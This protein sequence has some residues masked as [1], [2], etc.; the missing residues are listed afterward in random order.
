VAH[1]LVA[2]RAAR[3]RIGRGRASAAGGFSFAY[4]LIA[5]LV[6]VAGTI[7]LLNRTS[8]SLLGMASQRQSLQAREAARIGMAYLIS[9]INRPRNRNLLAVSAAQLAA[10]PTVD[11]AIWSDVAD[12]QNKCFSTTTPPNAAALP[13]LGDLRLAGGDTSF[14]YIQPDGA[15]TGE[16]LNATLAFRVHRDNQ[17]NN[18][19]LARRS[20]LSLTDAGSTRGFFRLSVEGRVLAPGSERVIASTILQEDF[21]V[22]PK[23]CGMS[24][25]GSASTS[26]GHGSSDFWAFPISEPAGVARSLSNHLSQNGVELANPA[27]S[28]LGRIQENPATFVDLVMPELP[29]FPGS[30][31]AAPLRL[32]TP[33]PPVNC[34]SNPSGI[35]GSTELTQY[36]STATPPYTR[37]NADTV[38]SA[39]L[40]GNCVIRDDDLHCAITDLTLTSGQMVFVSG[41]GTRRIRLYFADGGSII[42][43]PGD[44]IH[45][46]PTNMPP[47]CLLNNVANITDLSIFG[48]SVSVNPACTSVGGT[49]FQTITAR[50]PQVGTGFF[51]Y[52][53]QASVSIQY[54]GIGGNDFRGVV[55]ARSIN[56]TAPSIVPPV[57]PS[58]VADAFRLVGLL[59]N[60]SNSFS[61]S[62]IVDGSGY[63]RR[64]NNT[65]L[66]RRA[67]ANSFE[68][69]ARSTNRFRFIGN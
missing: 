68:T 6:L 28:V 63:G 51:V 53:P 29:R 58:G 9:Q 33:G 69:I 43:G 7:T 50:V 4:V 61:N 59:P 11:Q 35:S 56:I 14:F 60:A 64:N 34:P 38:T 26:T 46:K 23:P 8:S 27:E 39:N 65:D 18:F 10:N 62:L 3:R 52:A 44:M 48:C 21:D 41:N 15:I 57:H 30:G 49:P 2:H 12:H 31:A 40:P 37:F 1:R 20:E 67:F 16:R 45:C 47:N 25:V 19:R 22:I 66:V 24:F 32:C 5:A 36:I 17:A 42:F 55:W 54:S 13:N